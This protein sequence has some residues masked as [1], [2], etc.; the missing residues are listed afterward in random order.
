MLH[1][2]HLVLPDAWEVDAL[3]LDSHFGIVGVHYRRFYD[4]CRQIRGRLDCLATT[5]SEKTWRSYSACRSEINMGHVTTF[6]PPSFDAR[7]NACWRQQQGPGQSRRV[8]MTFC[9]ADQHRHGR[10]LHQV[11]HQQLVGVQRHPQ[12]ERQHARSLRAHRLRTEAVLP[13]TR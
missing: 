1:Q 5:R 11:Q 13:R 8:G 7:A 10:L 6:S 2:L 4:A 12:L 3:C 9:V